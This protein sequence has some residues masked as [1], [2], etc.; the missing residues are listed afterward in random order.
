MFT[1]V[2]S[3]VASFG[4]LIYVAFLSNGIDL[5]ELPQ[6]KPAK[7]EGAPA[8]GAPADPNAPKAE[9]VAPDATDANAPAAAAPD[10]AAP[11]G[12]PTPDA[13]KK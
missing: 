12:S 4:I 2:A 8:G 13:A 5:K 9:G 7:Q 11:A 1:F 10:A 6:E 3:M